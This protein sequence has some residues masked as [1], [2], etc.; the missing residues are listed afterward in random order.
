MINQVPPI[1]ESI[2]DLSEEIRTLVSAIRL[3]DFKEESCYDANNPD[4]N[5]NESITYVCDFECSECG[6]EF[7]F[8]CLAYKKLKHWPSC[9]RRIIRKMDDRHE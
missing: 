4:R 1:E 6:T 3:K 5:V 7:S 9:G 8:T 2:K